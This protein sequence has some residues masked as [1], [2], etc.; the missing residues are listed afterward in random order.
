M[1]IEILGVVDLKG[2]F[3]D[4]ILVQLQSQLTEGVL[5]L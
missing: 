5:A 1:V 3:A 4:V 2:G